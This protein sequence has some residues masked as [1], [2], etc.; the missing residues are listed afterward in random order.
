MN[1][2][3]TDANQKAIDSL[4]NYET[5]K[6]FGAEGREAARYDSAMK[7]YARA[8]LK[9]AYSLGA[10]NFG[11]S[12]IITGGLIT[13]MVMAARGVEAGTMT[14]GDFVMVN[15]YMIQ[16]TVPLN[17]LGTVYREIRQSLVDM[18]EMF[19]L[20]GQPA[21]VQDKAGAGELQVTGGEIRLEDVRFA[22]EPEREILK[23]CVVAG[24]CRADGGDCRLYRVGKVHHRAVVV[25]LL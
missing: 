3:D 15:A 13:V 6:Y 5:V 7:G 14:V 25:P 11:Q 4:L 18:G 21:D 10:L 16:I 1:T 19:D 22:Y 9:T 17:F 24:R 12:L 20:L 2:Q 8:A 23:G